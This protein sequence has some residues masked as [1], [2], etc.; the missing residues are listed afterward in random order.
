MQIG[1]QDWESLLQPDGTV[2]GIIQPGAQNFG[3][4]SIKS[5]DTG[6]GT[7]LWSPGTAE[8][9]GGFLI[10]VFSSGLVTNVTGVPPNVSGTT[11][12]GHLAIYLTSTPIDATQGIGGYAAAGGGCT[13]NMLCY[14]GV[15]DVGAAPF[16]TLDFVSGFDPASGTTALVS[17]FNGG[18][19]PTG[20][21]DSYLDVTGGSEAARF[22]TNGFPV[23]FTDGTPAA[24]RDM[25]LQNAFC[26]NG[27]STCGSGN[28]VGDWA[29]QSTDPIR[30]SVIPE[31]GTVAL[32]GIA[33]LALGL[34]GRRRSRPSP[35]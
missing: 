7:H 18:N 17:Q 19:P 27:I 16:L 31:P 5:M 26:P 4:F 29:L 8:N 35:V 2:G 28:Q 6:G 33:A 23:T 24:N 25:F 9:G 15:T 11:T 32:L 21:A 22:D 14:H 34:F 1:F 12:G 13:V 10:G 30:A 20:S 3:V